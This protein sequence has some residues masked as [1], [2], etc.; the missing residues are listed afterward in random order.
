MDR[1]VKKKE[2]T[3]L[4]QDYLNFLPSGSQEAYVPAGDSGEEGSGM[5][6]TTEMFARM[7]PNSLV[8]STYKLLDKA[9]AILKY[10]EPHLYHSIYYIY[11]VDGTGHSDIEFMRHRKTYLMDIAKH[12][13]AIDYLAEY[14]IDS[15]LF[16]RRPEKS[17]PIK[18]R[19]EDMEDKHAELVSV[20]VR[21]REEGLKHFQAIKNAALK[22]DYHVEHA[23]KIIKNKEP[24]IKEV[25]HQDASHLT[26]WI[27]G[28]VR[29]TLSNDEMSLFDDFVQEGMI[30]AMLVEKGTDQEM[31][32][33][34][35]REVENKLD[36]YRERGYKVKLWNTPLPDN[37]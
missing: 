5:P 15:D 30:A 25:I 12:D 26:T 1:E 9:L 3:I 32:N 20:Y 37:L 8:G 35:R 14:L 29:N 22:C 17:V 2:I 34:A 24:E 33:A 4:L 13:L 27:K 23:R 21:Y 28:M 18:S 10:R 16:V 31:K 11:L 19:R 6:L 7:N 36:R